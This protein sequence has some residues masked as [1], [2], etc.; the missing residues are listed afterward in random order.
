MPFTAHLEWIAWCHLIRNH[1]GFFFTLL[2]ITLHSLDPKLV[3]ETV[4][5]EI[6]H[7]NTKTYV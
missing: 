1:R 4:G 2:Y 6:Y 3:K 7:V 5:Y